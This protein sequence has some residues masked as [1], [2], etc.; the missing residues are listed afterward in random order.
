M[1][2]VDQRSIAQDQGPLEHVAQLTDIAGPFVTAQ[3][4]NRL[5]RQCRRGGSELAE[6]ASRKRQNIVAPLAE[7]RKANVEDVQTVIEIRTEFPLR[8]RIVQIAIGGGDDA[9][10][11]A[12]R[13][14]PAQSQELTLLEHAQELRLRRRRHLGDFVEEQHAARGQFNLARLRLLRARESSTLESEEL[15]LEELL[16]QRRAIDRDEWA[17]PSWRALVDEPRDDFLAGARLA[18]QARRRFGR[19]HLRRAPDDFTPRLRCADGGVDMSAG[20]E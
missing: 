15:G 13:P 19:G 10:V 9:N 5:S 7:R 2:G 8:H 18:L 6:K 11:N 1:L 14:R 4:L 17:A 3:C 12:N 16:R 20:I